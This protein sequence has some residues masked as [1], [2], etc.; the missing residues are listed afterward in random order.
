MV[1]SIL[2]VVVAAKDWGLSSMRVVSRSLHQVQ[3]NLPLPSIPSRRTRTL[4]HGCIPANFKERVQNAADLQHYV[5]GMFDMIYTLDYLE[6][7]S[8]VNEAAHEKR[9]KTRCA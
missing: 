1:R 9:T 3:M 6:G 7:T 4:R 2:K 5:H 8:M